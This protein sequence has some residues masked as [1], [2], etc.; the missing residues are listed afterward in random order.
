MKNEILNLSEKLLLTH[1]GRSFFS[2]AFNII[3]NDIVILKVNYVLN[4]LY[5]CN[6]KVAIKYLLLF[7]AGHKSNE[8]TIFSQ[9]NNLYIYCRQ[10]KQY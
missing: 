4:R 5:M 2:E 3:T 7:N 10:T 9:S 8:Y 6:G 1:L